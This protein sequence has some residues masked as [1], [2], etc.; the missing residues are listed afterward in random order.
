MIGD[1]ALGVARILPL[2]DVAAWDYNYVRLA[3]KSEGCS[4][5][6]ELNVGLRDKSLESAQ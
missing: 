4:Q 6:R 2:P 5:W 3:G 1:F